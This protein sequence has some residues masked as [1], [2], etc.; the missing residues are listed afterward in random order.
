MFLLFHLLG[1]PFNIS[2]SAQ[3]LEI[4]PQRILLEMI[5]VA[6]ENSQEFMAIRKNQNTLHRKL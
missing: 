1:F 6:R 3:E 5:E 4:Y 2:L